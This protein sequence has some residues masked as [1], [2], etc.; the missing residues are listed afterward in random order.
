MELTCRSRIAIKLIDKLIVLYSIIVVWTAIRSLVKLCVH[1]QLVSKF[2]ALD[3]GKMLWFQALLITCLVLHEAATIPN[4]EDLIELMKTRV[5]PDFCHT[6][7]TDDHVQFAVL[8]LLPDANWP[9]FRYDPGKENGIKPA[10]YHGFKA[11]PI[12]PFSSFG[13]YMAYGLDLEEKHSEQGVL[14]NMDVVYNSFISEYNSEPQAL[15]F[16]SWIVP[17]VDCTDDII[18][19][20]TQEPYKDIPT[21]VVAYTTK[22]T[23][24]PGCNEAYTVQTLKQT[25]IEPL[26]I[27]Y[28]CDSKHLEEAVIQML[29]DK[30]NLK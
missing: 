27:P 21:K 1:I 10:D 19:K 9:N 8:L 2:R 24:V 5:I 18:N 3:V 4:E 7:K 15:V 28:N 17:C 20:L 14:Q 30:L 23:L 26:H 11:F 6:F 25:N 13:N 22:G 16:Y 29:L 12:I